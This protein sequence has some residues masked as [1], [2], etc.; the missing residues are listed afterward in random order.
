MS[1]IMN[2]QK[3]TPNPGT[4][5]YQLLIK[6]IQRNKRFSKPFCIRHVEFATFRKHPIIDFEVNR[7]IDF[8]GISALTSYPQASILHGWLKDSNKIPEPE[9]TEK[10][11]IVAEG[12]SVGRTR[13]CVPGWHLRQIAKKKSRMA[14]NRRFA[15]TLI[16]NKHLKAI[17][18]HNASST[19]VQE[20]RAAIEVLARIT[21]VTFDGNDRLIT[22]TAILTLKHKWDSRYYFRLNLR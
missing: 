16:S 18:R 15:S 17:L 6:S 19:Q 8:Q 2:L 5:K 12:L 13:N 20:C 3:I 4:F 21:V 9:W 1:T 10:T 22:A 14:L 7:K 11:Q